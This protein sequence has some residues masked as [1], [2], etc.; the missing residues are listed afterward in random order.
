[1][2]QIESRNNPI[3]KRALK[4]LNNPNA[5][6]LIVV[7]GHKLLG[8]ALKSGARPEILFVTREEALGYDLLQ[9]YAEAITK[10]SPNLSSSNLL[11]LELSNNYD[12]GS[13][14]SI[15]YKIPK[16]L[17][18][19]LSTVQTPSEIIAFLTP[20]VSP[21]LED[22]VKT[23]EMLVVLDRLQDPGNI[24][25]II[26]TSEAMGVS[27]L[28]LLKGCCNQH[29]HKVIRAAMGSY[30]RLPIVSNVDA[31]NLFAILNKNGYT[32]MCADMKG[33][34]LK[35]FKFPEKSA[36]FMGQE[37]QGLSDYIIN[38]CRARVAIPMYGQVESLNVATS[39]AICLYEW[40]RN[41]QKIEKLI[42]V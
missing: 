34:I 4:A 25:T 22:I 14:N 6:N 27:A 42:F 19:E 9:T 26:R 12:K 31:E 39:T 28:I 20:A 36:L 21:K 1:M 15:T 5:E 37:G 10:Q 11:S 23:S 13:F 7:E 17:M 38:N 41:K 18:R 40:S 32:T 30:F 33:T 24:G 16:S 3:I 2:K 8:E 35:D 29:N